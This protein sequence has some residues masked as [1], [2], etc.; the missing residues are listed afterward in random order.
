[1]EL[2]GSRTIAAD[3]MTV[4]EHLNDADTLRES[5]PG[6]EELSGSAE[7]GFSATVKQKIGPVKATFKGTVTLSDVVVG[8]SYRIAG[9]GSGGVA[10]F[11]RGAARVRLEEVADGTELT[12]EV[13]AHVG[14]KIAQLGAR[15]IH[16]VARKMAD[17]F[18][19]N[20]QTHVEKPED[21]A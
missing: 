7:E 14:G 18:F 11:A 10:G 5:I 15:L 21:A 12:Y 20:F 3:R 6:C 19:D 17:Q 13:E 4:W 1:M 16:G 2:I 9:E 8:E